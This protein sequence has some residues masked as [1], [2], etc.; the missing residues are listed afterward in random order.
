MTDG[1]ERE[2]LPPWLRGAP[3]TR[4]QTHRIKAKLRAG[5]LHTVCEAARCPNLAQCFS[6]PTATFLLL[7]DRCTRGCTFCAVGRGAAEPPD[8]NEPNEVARAARELGLRHVVL[9]SVTRD[10]LPDGG[11]GHFA[12]T[13]LAVRGVLPDASVEV[14][15]PDFAAREDSVRAV[16]GAGP[17]VFNHN[18]ETVPR[19]YPAVRPGADFARSVGLLALARRLAPE[20]LIKSGMMVGLGETDDEV[21]EVMGRLRAAGCDILTIGQYLRPT[22]RNLPVDRW[23]PP[24]EFTRWEAEGR[25]LGFARVFAGPLVR[26]SYSA[27]EVATRARDD[28][29]KG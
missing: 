19:L 16:A 4:G 8:P 2:R 3:G 14:L 22:R 28:K 26:S 18:V 24:E 23:V 7:G 11:A 12:R 6:A 29:R 27:A 25:A 10:D 21:R 13:I 20:A 5:R 9:T 1:F 15:V 17:D